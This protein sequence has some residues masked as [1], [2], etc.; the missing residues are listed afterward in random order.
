M[1]FFT[2]FRESIFFAWH[3]LTASR[4]RTFLS[5][6]GITIGIFA[7]ITV[8]TVVDALEQNVRGSVASMGDD[9]IFVQK[10][11]WEFGNSEYPWWK[12]MNRPSPYIDELPEI[13]R[14]SNL[15]QSAAFVIDLNRTLQYG[16]SNIENV[17]V[18]CASAEYDRVKN[19]ELA[20][21]RYFS[22]IE[23]AAGRPVTILG[24]AVWRNLFGSSNPIGK[25]IRAGS[26][27][28]EVVGVFAYEGSS[29]IGVSMDNLILVPVN[30]ARNF[31]DL[32]SERINPTIY[33]RAKNGINNE[34]LREELTG[35]MRSVRKLKPLQDDSFALNETSMLTKSFNSLFDIIGLA[36]WVIGGFSIIVGGF[37]I[38]NIMFVSVKERTSQIGVQ[39][40][41]GARSSFILMQF[42]V[43]SILLSLSGG[44]LGLLVVFFG[45][46][47]V[48]N[49][50]DLDIVL[51]SSNVILA[52]TISLLI[53][54]ISGFVPSYTAS[55]LDPVEAMR[56]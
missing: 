22:P 53:G 11:P 38:A 19:F 21:G 45:L 37:G 5:L 49:A 16:S 2:L 17:Q 55:Q 10:W 27:R 47:I 15:A 54:L 14:Q 12:Y 51:S 39:K 33:V 44:V 43:E 41:L 4:L 26:N 20:D 42:L 50:F 30:F 28:L 24:Y 8:F 7:I 52:L 48:N 46:L 32:R 35:I 29:A 56:S 3:A 23:S 13:K 31:V 6:L 9:V 34:D 1:L 18:T 25:I 36:G 40:A